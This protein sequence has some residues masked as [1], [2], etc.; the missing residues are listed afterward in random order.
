[1]PDNVGSL[2]LSSGF[3]LPLQEGPKVGALPQALLIT[4]DK[5]VASVEIS[6]AA[7]MFRLCRGSLLSLDLCWQKG[8]AG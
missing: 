3:H 7:E 1:M 6:F 5:I 2:L 8:G 4:L